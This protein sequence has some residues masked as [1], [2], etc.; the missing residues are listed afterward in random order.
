MFSWHSSDQELAFSFFP[1]LQA[2]EKTAPEKKGRISLSLQHNCNNRSSRES[3]TLFSPTIPGPMW[4][5][6]VSITGQAGSKVI[7]VI[8]DVVVS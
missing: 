2:P 3:Y 1:M 8:S 4:P 6:P 7:N 5:D